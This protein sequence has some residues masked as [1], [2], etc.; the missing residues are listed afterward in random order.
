[1]KSSKAV[2]TFGEPGKGALGRFSS[3]KV[4]KDAAWKYAVD[5][6]PIVVVVER[7]AQLNLL[8]AHDPRNA[9][10]VIAQYGPYPKRGS[11]IAVDRR[12]E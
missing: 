7:C 8:S 2:Y 4:A 5:H 6:R 11:V 10:I 12:C 3:R 1:M 9:P